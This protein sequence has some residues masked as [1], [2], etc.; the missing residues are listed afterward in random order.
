VIPVLNDQELFVL[1][2]Q[3]DEQQ[4]A[5]CTSHDFSCW[6]TILSTFD[7]DSLKIVGTL[8]HPEVEEIWD[9]YHPNGTTIWSENA[10]IA[11]NFHP[12]N[13]CTVHQ[14]PECSTVY[15]RYT[16]YGGYYVDE[17]IRMVKPELIIQTSKSSSK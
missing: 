16:E 12:Y 13:R 15:L 6:E 8:K 1:A 4:C 3:Q 17:R 10:P 2:S 9:E 5:H 7:R 14:C 11:V